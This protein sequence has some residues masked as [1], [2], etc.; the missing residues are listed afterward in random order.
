[1]ATIIFCSK[2]FC[3][4]KVPLKTYCNKS[5][6][7]DSQQST[8]ENYC[9]KKFCCD[10]S[11]KLLTQKATMYKQ[12]TLLSLRKQ[13]S[14]TTLIQTLFLPL[15]PLSSLSHFFELLDISLSLTL[16]AMATHSFGSTRNIDLI[17]TESAVIV[18]ILFISIIHFCW[19]KCHPAQPDQHANKSNSNLELGPLPELPQ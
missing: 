6:Y 5:F 15:I 18:V 3:Y 8:F 14:K 16:I 12:Q 17:E 13:T 4:N 7:W 10:R 9:N 2:K 1:M 19:K 11:I